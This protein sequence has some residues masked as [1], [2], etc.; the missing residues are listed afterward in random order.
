MYRKLGYVTLTELDTAFGGCRKTRNNPQCGCFT[1]S[2][3]TEQGKKF[4]V[5]NFQVYVRYR[6]EI[7]ICF[8]DTGERD[9]SHNY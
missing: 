8:S 2:T 9:T 4:T 5:A 6:S 1:A 7:T 3:R